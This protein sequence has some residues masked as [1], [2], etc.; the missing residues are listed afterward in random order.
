MASG[1]VL[2]LYFLRLQDLPFIHN[3][4]VEGINDEN[5]KT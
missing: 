4:I 3:Y 1:L 2:T 5:S